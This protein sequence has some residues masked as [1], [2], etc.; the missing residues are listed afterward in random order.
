MSLLSRAG[1]IALA[2]SM[3]VGGP[4]GA[5]TKSGRARMA[6][7]WLSHQQNDDGS[8]GAFSLIG[9]TAD[10][11]VSFV[12]AK[13]SP[14]DITE[15]L[16]YLEE[17]AA[18]IDEI[19]ETAKV[20]MALEASGRDPRSF[21]GRDL[22]QH[23]L[24]SEQPDG[25]YGASTQVFSHALAVLALK[26]ADEDPSEAATDW[27]LDAQCDDGGWQFDE[28]SGPAEDEH[29]YDPSGQDVGSDTDTTAY[30][31]I[32]LAGDKTWRRGAA[33]NPFRFFKTRRDPVKKGWGYDLNYPIT[34]SNS[35]AL[36]IEAYRSHDKPVPDGALRA[37]MKLQ[38]RLCG[39]RAGAF[40]F[41]Y[42]N[43]D[44]K[45]ERQAPDVGATIGSILGLVAR[46]YDAV[47][48]TKPPP[49]PES[50]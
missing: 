32:A 34:S 10:A 16:G 14:E 28:P 43:V 11:V 30:A 42:E 15:A 18:D 20:V 21:D 9:S 47:S 5:A 38:Y 27:L 13:R 37:L 33:R 3:L 8:F 49:E 50:C 36:V 7:H 40:A 23:I 2:F 6:V 46:P 45:W 41:S 12:A 17:R 24:D 19:G 25:R 48:V 26:I 44:G 1:A 35:T 22:V 29:C 39:E 31:A 4:A